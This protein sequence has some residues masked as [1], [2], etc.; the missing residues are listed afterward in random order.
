MNTFD[1]SNSLVDLSSGITFTASPGDFVAFAFD[2][3]VIKEVEL[4]QGGPM[5]VDDFTFASDKALPFGGS[6]SVPEPGSGYLLL[7]AAALGLSA[8][9][10]AIRK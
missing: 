5:T 1:A 4:F 7:T 2:S 10:K 8:V 3:S 9:R 6:S